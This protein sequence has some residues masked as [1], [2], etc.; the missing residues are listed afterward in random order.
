MVRSSIGAAL[1]IVAF[2]ASAQAQ[3]TLSLN[4]ASGTKPGVK[5]NGLY[6]GSSDNVW[7]QLLVAG[8]TSL[9]GAGAEP[10]HVTNAIFSKGTVQVGGIPGGAVAEVTLRAWDKDT[11]VDY[12][13]ATVRDSVTFTMQ[14]GGVVDSNGIPGLPNSIV[15]A[16]TGLNLFSVPS[17]TVARSGGDKVRIAWRHRGDG[18]ALEGTDTLGGT[19]EPVEFTQTFDG[20]F[21]VAEVATAGEH[22]F[23][24]L[25][26]P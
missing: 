23:Y 4:V 5:R 20:T 6:V 14:L 18:F 22:Q 3:G 13:N 7:L 16:F 25:A 24:R 19:W 17:L 26:K 10:F 15:P 1:A 11:G 8:A 9:S 2:V 21:I 12:D